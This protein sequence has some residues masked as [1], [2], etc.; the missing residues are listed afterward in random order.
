MVRVAIAAGCDV[1]A[2]AG[3]IDRCALGAHVASEGAGLENALT[4]FEGLIGRSVDIDRQYYK[5]DEDAPGAHE[6][7]TAALG[8]LPVISVTGGLASGAS[9]L[10]D[11]AFSAPS[12]SRVCSG[13]SAL[14]GS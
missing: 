7:W 4:N 3:R 14:E 1:D 8:H 11:A 9:S 2:S 5:L 10:K 12:G 13:T 6:R